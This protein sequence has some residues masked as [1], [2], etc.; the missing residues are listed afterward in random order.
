MV[1]RFEFCSLI[2]GDLEKDP[3]LISRI[4]YFDEATFTSNGTLSSQ[5]CWRSSNNSNFTLKSRDRYS[6]KTNVCCSIYKY[7]VIGPYFIRESLNAERY[8]HILQ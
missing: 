1:I 2:Q 7:T 3:F 5:I 8:I 6:F 4:I